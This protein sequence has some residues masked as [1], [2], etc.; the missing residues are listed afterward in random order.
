MRMMIF[1][2]GKEVWYND[3]PYRVDYVHV[4]GY[5]LFLRLEGLHDLVKAED[6]YCE[7]TEL[8]FK[9]HE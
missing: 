9:R 3:R 4:I 6:V 1:T 7:P 8:D 2:R 5:K